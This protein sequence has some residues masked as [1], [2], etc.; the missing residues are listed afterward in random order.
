[1]G[2]SI[3]FP[4]A[5]VFGYPVAEVLSVDRA[6]VWVALPAFLLLPAPP[7]PLAGRCRAVMLLRGLRPEMELRATREAMLVGHVAL[8]EGVLRTPRAN[9]DDRKEPHA[10]GQFQRKLH[11][12][13][14]HA[15]EG[16]N[17]HANE[18]LVGKFKP[19]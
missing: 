2:G 9:G 1:V 4:V 5:G 3:P 11:G 12:R 7:L 13:V 8:L 19:F 10:L 16:L 18:N 14:I 15:F 17:F 6:L